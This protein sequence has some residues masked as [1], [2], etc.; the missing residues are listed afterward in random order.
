M[1]FV[2]SK[3]PLV[4]L[5]VVSAVALTGCVDDNYDL[6]NID[7]T[8]RIEVNDL[9]V[10]V[11]LKPVE[12]KSVIELS[13]NECVE[14]NESGEYVLTQGGN[15]HEVVEIKSIESDPVIESA[16]H[17]DRVMLASG[18]TLDLSGADFRTT[19]KFSYADKE[20]DKYIID[21]EKADVEFD[22]TIVLSLRQAA[23]PVNSAAIPSSLKDFRI[24][25]PAGL[26]GYYVDGN[27]QRHDV[28]PGDPHVATFTGDAKLNASNDYRFVYHVTQIDMKSSAVTFSSGK[29]GYNG[30]V[31]IAGG[32]LSVK[33]TSLKEGYLR[34]SLE[35]GH[36]KV[37][38]ITGIVNYIFTEIENQY[39]SLIDLPDVLR[40]EQTRIILNNPQ[41]YV[42]LNNPLGVYGMS[43][44][45]GLTIKQDRPAGET[46]ES[47]SLA[48]RLHILATTDM[49]TYVL[50]PAPE[51]LKPVA[52]YDGAEPIVFN[53]LDR[54]IYGNGLPEGLDISFENPSLDRCRVVDFPLGSVLGELDGSYKFYAPLS[55]GKG[56]QVIYSDD[57]DGWDI[58][59]GD[60]ED[61]EISKLEISAHLKS[62]LPVDVELSAIPLDKDGN[63]I[64]SDGKPVTVSVDPA[65]IPANADREITIRLSGAIKG[66]DGMRYTVRLAAEETTSVLRSD[67]NLNLTDIRVKVSGFYQSNDKD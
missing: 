53:G 49:Q 31:G 15:L 8:V 35:L 11:N 51:N 23:Q 39:V 14:E 59:S 6:E 41:L 2:L 47:A 64:L 52:G 28:K 16:S 27:G 43:G 54:I 34:M 10:P 55:F 19:F 44:T 62:D 37:T 33:N 57:Q 21:L 58:M 7:E 25:L 4:A 24:E 29:F 63:E 32:L 66:L 36:L 30:V 26:Y 9:V 18:M 12:F 3:Y 50:A 40:D 45:T 61:F 17:V 5:S 13:D 42:K 1:S 20:V 60:N 65:V 67:M 38:S 56:S 22:L 48:N 46:E